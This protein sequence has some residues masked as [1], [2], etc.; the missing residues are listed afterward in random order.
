MTT[1]YNLDLATD[2]LAV[3]APP[4]DGILTTVGVLGFDA[5]GA[6]GFDIATTG[7]AFAALI[8]PDGP[9][10]GLYSINLATGAATPAAA[11]REIGTFTGVT[12]GKGDPVVAFAAKGAVA[13]DKAKPKV[14]VKRKGKV[15]TVGCSE[16]C[17]IAVRGG[18]KGEVKARPGKVK[19]K[20]KSAAKTTVTVTDAAGNK[21][22]KRG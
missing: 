11:R 5:T 21:T 2:V 7:G 22:S 4:N 14:T 12:K 13:D 8:G 10:H 6:A 3:Q 20:S 19:V 18:G 9:R 17:T 16:A 15:L 1:L